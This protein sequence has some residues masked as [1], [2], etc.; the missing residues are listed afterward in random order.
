MN[1]DYT[2]H[3]LEQIL[4]EIKAVHELVADVPTRGAFNRLEQKMDK[5]NNDMEVVKTA[6]KATNSDVA[7]LGRDIEKHKGLPAHMA[8]GRA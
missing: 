5:L 1:D 4:D 8:H 3:L 2:G 6:V 7:D